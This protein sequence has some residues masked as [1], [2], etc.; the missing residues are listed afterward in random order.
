[1]SP[2]AMVALGLVAWWAISTI[3]KAKSE[4]WKLKSRISKAERLEAKRAA[5][6]VHRGRSASRHPT[7]D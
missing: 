1:V 2:E 6:E 5:N 3:N 7:Q 4:N